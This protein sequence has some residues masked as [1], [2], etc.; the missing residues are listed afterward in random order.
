MKILLYTVSDFS[1]HAKDCIDLLLQSI[2]G[3][4]Y[5][6]CVLTNKHDQDSNDYNII[7]DAQYSCNYIGG[8]KYQTNLLSPSYDYYI[9]LDSDILYFDSLDKLIPSDHQ[10]FS[11]V[12]ETDYAVGDSEWF[13]FNQADKDDHTHLIYSQALNAGT[14]VYNQSE[15][16]T[17]LSIYQKYIQYHTN[18]IEYDCKLEQSIYNYVINKRINFNNYELY[19]DLSNITQ[20]F[21]S[22]TNFRNEKTLYHFCGFSNEMTT[23]YRN[24]KDF[25]DKYQQQKRHN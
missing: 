20:L 16:N 14:F 3:T 22:N 2:H 24:M 7:Y 25:Y 6:F 21:A 4:N 23:K 1:N 15:I 9:Y 5:D 11:V 13:L 17:I 18:R 8:L 19:K 10:Y 12:R